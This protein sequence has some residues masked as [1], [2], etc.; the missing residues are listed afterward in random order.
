MALQKSSLRKPFSVTAL[1]VAHYGK[2][3]TTLIFNS[4]WIVNIILWLVKLF[5][6]KS[7]FNSEKILKKKTLA[8]AQRN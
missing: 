7:I 1:E 2:K 3:I 8:G 5:S 6:L 4:L